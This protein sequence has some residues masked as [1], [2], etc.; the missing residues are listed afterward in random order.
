MP[1]AQGN[2]FGRVSI[3]TFAHLNWLERGRSIP[4]PNFNRF[5]RVSIDT[6]CLMNKMC[7]GAPIDT[8]FQYEIARSTD[9]FMSKCHGSRLSIDSLMGQYLGYRVS[10]QLVLTCHVPERR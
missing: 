4:F 1:I 6:F 5:G 10:V 3:N 9:S 8:Q 7:Q 2:R